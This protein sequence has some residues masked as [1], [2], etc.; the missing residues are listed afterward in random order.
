MPFSRLI[1]QVLDYY[2]TNDE[3]VIIQSG[4]TPVSSFCKNILVKSYMVEKEIQD[5]LPRADLIITHGGT[6]S[7]ITAIEEGKV[8]IAMPRLKKYGEHNDDHQLE[9]IE[10]FSVGGH[11]LHWRDGISLQEMLDLAK[12]F[13]PKPYVSKLPGLLE[14]IRD[15]LKDFLK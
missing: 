10:M 7:I 13:K 5:I 2:G 6:G 8:V 11:I 3:E 15:D 1:D 12:K 4:V 9:I 14:S